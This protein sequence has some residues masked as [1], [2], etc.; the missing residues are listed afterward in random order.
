MVYNSVISKPSTS[1]AKEKVSGMWFL[2]NPPATR[3]SFHRNARNVIN[4]K[5][6][7]EDFRWWNC[8]ILH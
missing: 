8:S 1:K 5:M 4:I 7:G 6:L 2:K 3:N